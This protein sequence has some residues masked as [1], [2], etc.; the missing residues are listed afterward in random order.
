MQITLSLNKESQASL[1][2]QIVNQIAQLIECGMLPPGARL[3]SIREISREYRIAKNTAVSAY[4]RLESEG[5]I[6]VRQASGA[7]V[8]EEY[9][10]LKPKSSFIN[11]DAKKRH[12]SEMPPLVRT[13]EYPRLYSSGQY[14]LDFRLGQT[15]PGLFPLES[16][17]HWAGILLH[18]SASSLSGYI[19]PRGLPELRSEIVKHVRITRGISADICDVIIVQGIQEALSITALLMIDDQSKVLVES[20]GFRGAQNVFK[21]FGAQ[22]DYL[23]VDHNGVDPS[24][25]PSG[26]YRFLHVTPSHQFPL[27]VTLTAERRASLLEWAYKSDSYILE[28]DYDADYRYL[29]CPLPAIASKG[30]DRVIYVGTFSKCFGPGLRLG[31]MICPPSLSPFVGK[32]KAVMN[33]GC[34]WLE[35]AVVS[36]FMQSGEFISHLRSI[37]R[38]YKVLCDE[39]VS[40]LMAYGGQVIGEGGGTH[41]CWELP[42]WAPSAS[43]VAIKLSTYGI[44]VYVANETAVSGLPQPKLDNLLFLGFGSVSVEDINQLDKAISQILMPHR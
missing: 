20:P 40:K 43:D 42:S 32:A 3:P 2:N 39:L 36:R 27:G 28:N 11:S 31:Y 23:P 44:K 26:T 18:H 14:P 19:D 1:Q 17:Q 4:Q 41:V 37:R 6:I 10:R 35:Q 21:A 12:R 25:I 24:Y 38:Y 22:I 29:D 34:S 8:S 13:F 30:R 9:P 16:W 5:W 33:N 15:A 7:W